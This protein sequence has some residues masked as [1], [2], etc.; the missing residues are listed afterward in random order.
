MNRGQREAARLAAE[1]SRYGESAPLDEIRERY[2]R[3]EAIREA[4]YLRMYHYATA[5]PSVNLSVLRASIRFR[6]AHD[7]DNSDLLS[8]A[9]DIGADLGAI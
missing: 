3:D 4:D 2:S 7:R 8:L 1:T 6:L 9:N 5:D